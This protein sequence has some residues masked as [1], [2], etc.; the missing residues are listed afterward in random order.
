MSFL[1]VCNGHQECANGD[2]EKN[3]D[4]DTSEYYEYN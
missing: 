3:C 2:D 4:Q 1:G